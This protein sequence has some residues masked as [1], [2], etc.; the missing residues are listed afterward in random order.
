MQD[1]HDLELML[2]RHTP[3][4]LI[5]SWEE[6][7]V[8]ELLTRL[9]IKRG[10]GLQQWSLTDGLRRLG[11]GEDPGL[12]K[13]EA[14]EMALMHIKESDQG[15]IFV[16][17]DLH[18]FIEQPEIV[19][20]LKDIALQHERR[21]KTLVLVSH[22]L[23][24]PD[25]LQRLIAK[26]QL[27]LPTDNE[28]MALVQEEAR[29]YSQKSGRRV[30]SD[31]STIRQLVNNLKGLTLSD[32]RRLIRGAIVDDG[33]ITQ[34]DVPDIAKTRMQLMDMDSVLR[35]EYDTARFS[36]VAGLHALKNWLNQRRDS[37]LA[38][39]DSEA[40]ALGNRPKG[41][42]LFGIQGGGKSLAA[43]AVAGSWG[44]PLLNLDMGA[45]YNKFIGETE[46]NL[47]EALRLA[48]LMSPCV[49]W[50]DEIEKALATD[51]NDGGISQR[52]LGTL[53]T[54]MAEQQEQVFVVATANNIQALPP[55]FMRKGRL[56]EIFFVDLPTAEVRRAILE[57]HLNKRGLIDERLDLDRVVA[58]TQGFSGAELEQLVV[59]ACYQT[60][61]Q[62]QE[63]SRSS[64]K[65]LTKALTTEGLLAAARTTLPLSVTMAESLET[66]R[67]WAHQRAVAAD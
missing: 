58:D 5:E 14:P 47:R 1:V 3:I 30:K 55:E 4:I 36:E 33:A 25:E 2:E 41:M 59:S 26:F 17:C 45:M 29:H 38:A 13:S 40:K 35:F 37:F 61:P 32:A 46:R 19:R 21:N 20:L 48:E 9:G 18:P 23:E 22:R 50:M 52:L 28:L 66:L 51:Q 10:I 24:V 42:L 44:V 31:A 60:L 12:E 64:A 8:L 67:A 65:T 57:I 6:P 11:F 54:W 43:K 56:D 27:S 53:L 34:T 15:G 62:S 16:F 63:E 49:L 39:A 7:S